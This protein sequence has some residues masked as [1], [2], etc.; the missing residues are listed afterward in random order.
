[1]IKRTGLKKHIEKATHTGAEIDLIY[2]RN[3]RVYGIICS[4][5]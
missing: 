1:M 5:S 4:K 2:K 3:G